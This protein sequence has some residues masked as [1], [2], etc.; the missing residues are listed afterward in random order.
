MHGGEL[1]KV[2]SVLFSEM[3][4]KLGNQIIGTGWKGRMVFRAYK[5]PANPQTNPQK[6]HRDHQDLVLK[7]YQSNVGGDSTKEA[8]W[9]TDALPRAISGYNLFVKLG[10]SSKVDCDATQ[11][12]PADIDGHYTVT[13]DISS[14][15]LYMENTGTNAFTEIVAVGDMAAGDDIPF[16]VPDPGAGTYRFYIVD[17]RSK[18]I[19]PVHADR[20]AL[21]NSWEPNTTT[22]VADLAQCVYS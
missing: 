9:N 2:K 12:T 10:R 21:V 1:I 16:A 8:M 20:S 14:A 19:P 17:G 6:A 4:N 3:R 11:T 15:G 18:T 7:L 22:G 5:V 13:K